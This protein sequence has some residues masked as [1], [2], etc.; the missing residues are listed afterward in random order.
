[1]AKNL[2]WLECLAESKYAS[3]SGKTTDRKYIRLCPEGYTGFN[4]KDDYITNNPGYFW[5]KP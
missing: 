5:Q 1:M 2:Y 3:E 4:F